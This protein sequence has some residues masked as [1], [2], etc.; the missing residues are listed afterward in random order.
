MD[1]NGNG[2]ISLFEFKDACRRLALNMKNEEV[3]TVF[4]SLLNADGLNFRK[5]Y[6]LRLKPKDEQ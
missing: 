4:K 1:V 3:E 2:Q 5:N 6:G